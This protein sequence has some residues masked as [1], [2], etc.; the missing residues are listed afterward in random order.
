MKYLFSLEESS[1]DLLFFFHETDSEEEKNWRLRNP[2]GYKLLNTPGTH[3]STSVHSAAQKG[4][5]DALKRTLEAKPDLVNA[6]DINGWTPLL[7]SH[8]L[9]WS[10]DDWTTFIISLCLTSYLIF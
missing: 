3:G 7:V 5:A 9:Q 4:D 2:K 1:A 10:M 6:K 8:C